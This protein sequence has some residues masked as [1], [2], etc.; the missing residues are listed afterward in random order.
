MQYTII[1][2][3]RIIMPGYCNLHTSSGQLSV[4]NALLDR[5]ISASP[6]A[7]YAKLNSLTTQACIVHLIRCYLAPFELSKC[8]NT[9]IKIHM[10]VDSF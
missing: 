3:D 9:V 2:Y 1:K 5:D 7:H 6:R 8:K 4:L 10:V